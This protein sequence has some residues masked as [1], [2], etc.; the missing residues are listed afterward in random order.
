V[1]QLESPSR[2]EEVVERKRL[3]E[4][5]KQSSVG[6]CQLVGALKLTVRFASVSFGCIKGMISIESKPLSIPSYEVR[7]PQPF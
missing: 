5:A 4:Q 3:P 6:S 1:L 7:K 2:V